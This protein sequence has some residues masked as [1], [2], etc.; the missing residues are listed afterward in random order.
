MFHTERKRKACL[1][2]VLLLEFSILRVILMGKK[3]IFVKKIRAKSKYLM[4]VIQASQVTNSTKFVIEVFATIKRPYFGHWT[5]DN[6]SVICS[7]IS[8]QV[9]SRTN[10]NPTQ[11]TCSK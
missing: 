11:A 10:P 3:Q 9:A 6:L 1:T 5:M 7:P 2:L 8:N 4:F